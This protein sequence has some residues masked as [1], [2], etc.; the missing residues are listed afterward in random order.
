L[1]EPF[2]LLVTVA[3]VLFVSYQAH[4]A[5][6]TKVEVSGGYT[7]LDDV[8][9]TPL[10]EPNTLNGWAASVGGYFNDSFGVVAEVGGSYATSIGARVGVPTPSRRM[11]YSVMGGPQ[12]VSHQNPKVTPFVQ[13]LVGAARQNGGAFGSGSG[14][15][16][17]YIAVQPGG[18][19][20]VNMTPN[21]GLR[22]QVDYRLLLSF[23][24][25]NNFRL[26]I[27]IVFRN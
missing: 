20:D 3:C 4:A 15:R 17:N 2:V 21:L 8:S 14:D 22:L 23:G 7:F 13:V 1:T 10:P 6:P 18:G 5:D 27:G 26:L 9:G 12:F 11:E 24:T 25:D 19:V 16:E